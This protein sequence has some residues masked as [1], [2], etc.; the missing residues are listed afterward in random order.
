ML[1]K[2]FIIFILL[3]S[4]DLSAQTHSGFKT[5]R[6]LSAR[7]NFWVDVFTRYGKNQII[8]HHRDYPQAIFEVVDVSAEAR[9]YNKVAF[10]KYVKKF[11]KNK[12]KEIEKLAKSISHGNKLTSTLGRKVTDAFL[13]IPGGKSKYSKAIKEDLIRSQTGIKEKYKDAMVR[14]G[15]YLPL[16]EDIFTKE[17]KLPIELT[18]LPFVESSFDYKAYSSVGAAGIWQFMPRTAKSYM[19][20]NYLIDERRDVISATR[21]AAKYLKSAYSAL[22]TWPLAVTSYNHGVT[23]VKRKVKE[24]GTKDISKIVEHP[25]KR[26]LG[27]A[28]N[29]FFPELLAAIKVYNKRYQYFPNIKIEKQLQIENYKLKYA[30]SVS[31]VQ[32]RLGISRKELEE[33][34]YAISSRVWKGQYRIPSGYVLKVPARYK[35]KLITLRSPEPTSSSSSVVYG[36]GTYRVRSGD[37][38]IRISKKYGITVSKLKKLN[39]LKSNTIRI[40]QTLKVSSEAGSY[41]SGTYVVRKG[42]NLGKIASRNKTSVSKLMSI[43]G[44]R[45]S[46]I[47]V[48]QKLKLSLSSSKYHTVKNGES[49]WRISKKYGVSIYNIQKLNKI[50]GSVLR[51]GQK[52]RIK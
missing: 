1:K 24:I 45:N 3:L 30:T 26:V 38:L 31:H 19:K 48:G 29:N 20:V 33:Y 10:E 14:S 18:R 37:S 39:G 17:Y 52:L 47:Y 36:V 51:I 12:I 21:G 4:C 9:K 15:R 34:N 35:N 50:K 7:V 2:L 5:P 22:G 46:R 42:D 11:K 49:L 27:F 25:T 16:I 23:G 6:E 28:S 8:F 43:N 13:M 44:L 41:A 32:K 40:G